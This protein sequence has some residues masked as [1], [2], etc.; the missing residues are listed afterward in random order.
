MSDALNELDTE[1]Y[2]EAWDYLNREQIP[3]AKTVQKLVG[4]NVSPEVI[5]QRVIQRIGKHREPFALRVENAAK[6]LYAMKQ[7]RG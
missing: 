1:L 5:R 4:E 7:T 2:S 6:Y 3:I